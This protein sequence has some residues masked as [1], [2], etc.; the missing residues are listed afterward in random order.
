MAFP[1]SLSLNGRIGRTCG[2]DRERPCGRTRV[3]RVS[4]LREVVLHPTRVVAG[5]RNR[6]NDLLSHCKRGYV[7]RWSCL[8]TA[9][10]GNLYVFYFGEPQFM[11]AAVGIVDGAATSEEG[12]FDWTLR[13]KVWFCRFSPLIRLTH[14]V[15]RSELKESGRVSTWWRGKPYR[16]CQ[17]IPS[18]PGARLVSLILGRNPQ[19][20]SLL[21]P[22]TV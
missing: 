7:D 19:I 1:T 9:S 3:R 8:K 15:E 20:A 17:A 22:F 12:R 21:A 4:P 16:R 5:R 13:R 10:R 18:D 14:P 6:L 2:L 11:I